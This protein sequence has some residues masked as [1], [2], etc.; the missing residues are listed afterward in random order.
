MD[1]R[2]LARLDL[3]LLV[4]L[5]VLLEERNVSKAA[6]RLFVTQSAMSKT[7]GRLREL[8]DDPLFTRTARGMVPTPRAEQVATYLSKVLQG[9]QC[10]VQPMDFEPQRFEGEF[11]MALPEYVDMWAL[12]LLFER[13]SKTAPSIRVN[14]IIRQEH[15]LDMLSSGELDFVVQIERHS[16]P[17]EF[18]VKTLG[19]AP[20]RLFARRGHPLEGKQT[21][22][23][24]IA[25]YP[26]VSLHIPER[27]E[28]VLANLIDSPFVKYQRNVE[29]HLTTDHLFTALQ[30]VHATDYIFAGPPLFVELVDISKEIITLDIPDEEDVRFTFVIVQ[31]ERIADSVAHQFFYQ[32]FL[33]S[34]EHWRLQHNL[35]RFDEMQRINNLDY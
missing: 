2:D 29:P 32:Q 30:V 16:Y 14:T 7:L 25:Q 24:M 35:P 18:R 27:D 15:Q 13:L 31:H 26:H 6:E 28:S 3:N 11:T 22:W 33:Q 1:T 12:P 21:T 4:A 34:V 23:D 17:E 8:F 20:P 19:F 9:V 5:Q 10:I